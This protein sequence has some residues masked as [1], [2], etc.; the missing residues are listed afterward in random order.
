MKTELKIILLS[1]AAGFST[2]VLNAVLDFLVFSSG[3]SFLDIL[4]FS[5]TPS[6]L[7]FRVVLILVS[8][9]CGFMLS[10]YF[11]RARRAE[12]VLRQSEEKYRTLVENMQDG[13]F[14]IQD[15]R[16]CF[17]NKSL[18]AM[19]GYSVEETIG[20][21]FQ[22]LVAPEDLEIVRYRY[23]HRLAGEEVPNEYEFSLLHKDGKTRIRVHMVVGLIPFQ[24]KIATMG[25]IKDITRQRHIEESLRESKEFLEKIMENAINALYVLDLEGRCTRVNRRAS[26]MTGYSSEELIGKHFSLLISPD[27]LPEISRQFINVAVHG[28]TV[29]QYEAEIV[30]KDGKKRIITFSAV[31][32]LHDGRIISIV[33]SAED[34]TDRKRVGEELRKL[35]TAVEW[36][37]D[38]IVITDR[39][40]IIE[41]VN[42]AFEATTGYTRE[43]AIGKTPNILKSGKHGAQFYKKL[44]DELRAGRVF[45]AVFINRKKNGELFYDEHTITPIRDSRGIIT[46]YVS[47]TKDITERIQAEERLRELAE[48]DPLTN[49]YNRRKFFDSLKEGVERAKRYG[50]PLSLLLFDIDHFKKVNDTYGHD[51]GDAVLKTLVHIVEK[52][53]RKTDMFARYGGEEFTLFAPETTLQGAMELA[54]KI[55]QTVETHSFDEVGRI[56]VSIGVSEFK[57]GDTMDSLVR[58]AD[59]ALYLAKRK[60]RNRV[61]KETM[62]PPTPSACR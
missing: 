34:I 61:E 59:S 29:S 7:S 12:E 40:G 62:P 47:T 60:G 23:A 21:D 46:H 19:A 26:E 51:R 5:L 3:Q 42:P 25:T 15:S 39:N 56:T 22:R 24:G 13:I 1:V 49:I 17:V 41:Y 50:R 2:W 35:S 44:W 57:E 36:T 6:E 27:A 54:E 48:R 33:G 55:R 45:R 20:M 37:A 9:A 8:I 28:M 43:E 30:R 18:A 11:V 10:R 4:L 38:S 16:L 52:S 32:L 53:I 31:P 58:R 14:I